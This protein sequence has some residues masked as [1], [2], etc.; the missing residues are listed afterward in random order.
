VRERR[1]RPEVAWIHQQLAEIYFRRLWRRDAI[2]EWDEALRLEPSLRQRRA[3]QPELCA[4]LD[5]HWNGE[6][7]RLLLSR[8]GAAAVAPMRECIRSTKDRDILRAAVR[9]TEQV[10]PNRVD[11]GL[12]ATRE[13]DLAQTCEDR[14]AAVEQVA[15]LHDRR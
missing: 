1:A 11:R 3:L 6:T 12:V 2:R 14:R 8:F 10:A 7:E 15:E 13:L 9:V 5:P 4:A